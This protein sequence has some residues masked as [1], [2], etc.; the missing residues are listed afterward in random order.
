MQKRDSGLEVKARDRLSF[1]RAVQEVTTSGNEFLVPFRPV[2]IFQQQ[3]PALFVGPA[4]EAGGMEEHQRQEGEARR[5]WAVGMSAEQ[6]AKTRG[7]L[8]KVQA[9]CRL[10]ACGGV[11]LVE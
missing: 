4:I 3:Q 9:D 1:G 2:L 11:A 5:C 6:M 7:L 10:A 8:A